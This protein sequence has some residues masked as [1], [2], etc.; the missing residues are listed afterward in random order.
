[1]ASLTSRRNRERLS[2]TVS[3]RHPDVIDRRHVH[4]ESARQCDVTRDARA[5]LAEWL[6]GDLDTNP[7]PPLAFRKS[8]VAGAAE[9]VRAR[10]YGAHLSAAD[11]RQGLVRP[12]R[13]HFS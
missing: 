4:Q 2:A 13:C 11:G 8:V 12:P 5:L 3:A 6:L 7:R 10:G 9:R 1:M